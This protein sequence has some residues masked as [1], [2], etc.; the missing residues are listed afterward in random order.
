MPQE[1]IDLIREAYAYFARRDLPAIFNL[2]D[3][4]IEFYQSDLL[5]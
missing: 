3:R 4:D 2:F 5:L 1:N